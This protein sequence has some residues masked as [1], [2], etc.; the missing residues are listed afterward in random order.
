M[1]PARARC[2]QPLCLGSQG[3]T[4]KAAYKAECLPV[5][6][7]TGCFLPRWHLCKILHST[8]LPVFAG[9]AGEMEAEAGNE[10]PAGRREG[11]TG[12]EGRGGVSRQ[13]P[14]WPWSSSSRVQLLGAGQKPSAH[15]AYPGLGFRQASAGDGE[16][17]QGTGCVCRG[18]GGEM[19]VDSRLGRGSRKDVA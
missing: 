17:A 9:G 12:L 15:W 6:A 16:R 8:L 18:A 13:R 11:R 3:R 1:L 7:Q 2:V 14:A 19:A 5:L 10:K 4:L